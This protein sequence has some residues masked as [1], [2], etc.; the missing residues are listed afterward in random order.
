M[1]AF[2]KQ[3]R[4][5]S[6]AYLDA[7]RSFECYGC[8]APPP[9]MAHHHPPKGRRGDLDDSKTIPVCLRCH[10]RCHGITVGDGGVRYLPISD[11]VQT[12][13]VDATLRRFLHEAPGEAVA[14][15]FVELQRVRSEEGRR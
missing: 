7:V 11:G 5:P 1:T 13:A 4:F 6:E 10:Q 3:R 15:Y 2:P 8:E 14:A 12:A 9:S